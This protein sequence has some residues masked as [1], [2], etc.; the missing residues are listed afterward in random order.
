MYFGIKLGGSECNCLFRIFGYSIPPTHDK[1]WQTNINLRSN[2][3][4][5]IMKKVYMLCLGPIKSLLSLNC[6]LTAQ[7]MVLHT[8]VQSEVSYLSAIHLIIEWYK[9]Y[10]HWWHMV[11]IFV[12][13]FCQFYQVQSGWQYVEPTLAIFVCNWAN[14]I[15]IPKWPN[16]ER[17][18]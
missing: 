13:R 6:K 17:V 10:Q 9:K 16:I 3:P 4:N 18:S 12:K 7:G 11:T 14:S 15:V 5:R 2:K 8:D 1:N